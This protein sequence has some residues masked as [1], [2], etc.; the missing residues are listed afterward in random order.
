MRKHLGRLAAVLTWAAMSASLSPVALAQSTVDQ[1]FQR[2]QRWYEL[3]LEKAQAADAAMTQVSACL[4]QREAALGRRIAELETVIGTLA[5]EEA[6]QAAA[7]AALNGSLPQ[8]E[9]NLKDAERQSAKATQDFQNLPGR[10]AYEKW[11][12]SC[13]TKSPDW[14]IYVCSYGNR[15]AFG[16]VAKAANELPGLIRR[17]EIAR[18]TLNGDSAKLAETRR[19]LEVTR[20][21]LARTKEEKLGR[22]LEVVDVKKW[23]FEVRELMP[24][25]R[26]VVN[27]IES[28]LVRS[29]KVDVEDERRKTV[30][31]MTAISE[32]IDRSLNQV[33]VQ[34]RHYETVL[35]QGW[36]SSCKRG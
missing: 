18:D 16:E 28:S 13:D 10:V 25:I 22:N 20:Q 35:P 6:K 27:R 12:R 29:R 14:S 26:S 3:Q 23:Q 30:L 5:T 4:D 34:V 9:S 1:D 7:V 15:N 32:D 33:N 19:L 21:D 17:V 2:V 8:L 24:P 31:Q 36:D 11:K